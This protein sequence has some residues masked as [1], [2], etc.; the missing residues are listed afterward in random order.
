MK[1][2]LL[3]SAECKFTG[4]LAVAKANLII[5]LNNPVGIG[6]HPNVM[7]EVA[8]L[9]TEIHDAKGSL[10]I[11]NDMKKELGDFEIEIKDSNANS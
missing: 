11:I 3:E 10:E 9:V 2:F 8:K 1:N 6:E 5:Y 7:E 4:D